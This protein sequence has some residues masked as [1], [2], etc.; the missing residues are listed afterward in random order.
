MDNCRIEKPFETRPPR[1]KDL[2]NKHV[3]GDVG[4]EILRLGQLRIH[5]KWLTF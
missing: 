4:L 3:M 2:V 5:L 1:L